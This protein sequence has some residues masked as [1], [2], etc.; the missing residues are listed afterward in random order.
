MRAGGK[1]SAFQMV[2]LVLFITEWDVEI[3]FNLL[4]GPLRN[5]EAFFAAQINAE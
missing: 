4:K 1:I 3:T 2:F 5:R